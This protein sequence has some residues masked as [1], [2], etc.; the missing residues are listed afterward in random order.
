MWG[1]KL[2]RVIVCSHP[3][4]ISC[5]QTSCKLTRCLDGQDHPGVNASLQHCRCQ[6][7]RIC[8]QQLVVVI[9]HWDA[10]EHAGHR[11]Q[12]CRIV[13][14]VDTILM[15]EVHLKQR[16]VPDRT[17]FPVSTPTFSQTQ[18]AQA[19][20]MCVCHCLSTFNLHL[21]NAGLPYP[22]KYNA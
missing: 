4:W 11:C 18:L 15:R 10:T 6:Q 22:Q 8:S 9:C 1:C 17:A 19:F 2:F 21:G 20:W 13:E 14:P 7:Q 5:L 3:P 16:L 12:T